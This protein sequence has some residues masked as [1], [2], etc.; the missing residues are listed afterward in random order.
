MAVPF[1]SNMLHLGVGTIA[2]LCFLLSQCWRLYT[3]WLRMQCNFGHRVDVVPGH[4]CILSSRLPNII[5]HHCLERMELNSHI[6][7]SCRERRSV[8]ETRTSSSNCYV[9]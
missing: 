1:E 4:A 2:P 7:A 3:L 5:D 9:H 6:I 8:S